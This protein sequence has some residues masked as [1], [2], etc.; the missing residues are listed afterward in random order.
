MTESL[1]ESPGDGGAREPLA[2][3]PREGAGPG[4]DPGAA[5][6]MPPESAPT[7]AGTSA[8]A[9]EIAGLTRSF[10][11]KVAVSG[12]DL[13][14]YAGEFFGFLGPNGAGK[15][16][17]IKMLCGLLR[18]DSGSAKVLGFDVERESLEV[19]RR[20]GVLP[21]ESVLY[22][23][24]TPLEM[25]SLVGRLH[26][27]THEQIRDRSG[28]LLDLMEI[29]AADRRKMVLDFSQGMRKKVSLACALL[30]APRVLFLDEPFNGIDVVSVR[31][32]REVLRDAVARG[33]TIFFS[34]HVLELV[35]KLC[36]RIAII[37]QGKLQ[38]L[39]TLSEVR[40]QA[41]LLP[42]ASLEDVFVHVAG[43]SGAKRGSL[44][45]LG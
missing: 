43:R 25:L 7:L 2:E 4:A 29:A 9:V 27:L 39:G 38:V 30:P 18:P 44:E 45:F 19:R 28:P 5:A 33:V 35:E 17:T 1:G 12:L 32:I 15:S 10:G 8:V 11:S 23:R 41:G 34:S 13:K 40:S 14:V 26:G 42:E 31:G 20:I 24:L 6:E 36:T 22:E 3:V 21:E 37:A 16:T